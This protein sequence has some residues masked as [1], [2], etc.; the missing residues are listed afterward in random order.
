[1]GYMG[2]EIFPPLLLI[3]R[4]EKPLPDV[5]LWYV[6]L[7]EHV[8]QC[9]LQRRVDRSEHHQASSCV[10]FAQTWLVPGTLLELLQEA[11]S[12]RSRDRHGLPRSRRRIELYLDRAAVHPT[13]FPCCPAVLVTIC[14][15]C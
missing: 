7:G 2:E 1:M 13:L 8:A 6:S 4:H 5:A 10:M 14:V 11:F 9:D 12:S 15:T 3:Q